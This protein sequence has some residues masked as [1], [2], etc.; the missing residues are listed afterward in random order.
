MTSCTGTCKNTCTACTGTCTG[1]CD[2]ACTSTEVSSIIDN[3]KSYGVVYS[4]DYLDL[5]KMLKK[6]MSRRGYTFTS[7]P[8]AAINPD[9]INSATAIRAIVDNAK[10]IGYTTSESYDVIIASQMTRLQTFIRN[11]ANQKLKK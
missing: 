6:D 5:I 9:S 8:T 10:K 3:I 1:A 2:N 11:S 4:D 7:D